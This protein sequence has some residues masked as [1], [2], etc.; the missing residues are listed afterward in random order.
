[1]SHLM[2]TSTLLFALLAIVGI[3]VGACMNIARDVLQEDQDQ[4]GDDGAGR[5]AGGPGDQFGVGL[6]HAAIAQN[7]GLPIQGSRPRDA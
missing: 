3:A 5:M 2:L 7:P 1:M 6:R 4:E